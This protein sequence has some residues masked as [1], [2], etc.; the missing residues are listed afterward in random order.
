MTRG[1]VGGHARCREKLFGERT[2]RAGQRE[3]CRA[4]WEVRV[5]FGAT[6]RD[7]GRGQYLRAFRPCAWESRGVVI[8]VWA[9]APKVVRGS[10]S[11]LHGAALP[12]FGFLDSR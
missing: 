12:P 9:V 10:R 5:D 2:S 8:P 7:A 11:V 1:D 4:R 6:N 3:E